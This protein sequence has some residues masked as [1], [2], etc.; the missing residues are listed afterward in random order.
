VGRLSRS[1]V[2]AIAL[3]GPMGL[4]T[5]AA[6]HP[7]PGNERKRSIRAPTA[8]STSMDALAEAI[9]AFSPEAR[10]TG[11]PTIAMLR[12]KASQ[13]RWTNP[14]SHTDKDGRQVGTL[15][16]GTMT[17]PRTATVPGMTFEWSAPEGQP[18]N[19]NP[20]KAFRNAG[21]KV[22]AL[23]CAS[24]VS[25]GTNYF[26]VSAPGKRP[27]FLSIYAFD[28]PTATSVASW[29]ISYRLDG[30]I[31]SLA[32]VQNGGDLLATG[33]CSTETFGH[34]EQISH[35]GA[36]ALMKRMTSGSGIEAPR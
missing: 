16:G 13:V 36:V 9:L 18:L 2:G 26:V 3:I 23:Y 28:A 11:S 33:D 24:M 31:P 35:A 19:F 29:S 7:L 30:Y 32:E 17:I 4:A 1:V 8:H 34:V 5:A 15:G 12:A 14:R 22:Q 10:S 20:V 25:D 6:E 27:G 21:F